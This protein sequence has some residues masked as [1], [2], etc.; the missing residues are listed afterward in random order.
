MGTDPVKMVA[1]RKK[2]L[3]FASQSARFS[4]LARLTGIQS[5]LYL[6]MPTKSAK[7]CALPKKILRPTWPRRPVGADLSP[8][9]S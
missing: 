8:Q 5:L 4:S 2:N 6:L 9:I 7:V 1:Q 3:P